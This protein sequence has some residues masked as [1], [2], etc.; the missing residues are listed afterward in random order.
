MTPLA[1]F[2]GLCEV[3]SDDEVNLRR[4]Y[5]E[6]GYSSDLEVR[7]SMLFPVPRTQSLVVDGVQGKGR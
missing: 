1:L 5:P 3:V 7:G 4:G 2:G 6:P